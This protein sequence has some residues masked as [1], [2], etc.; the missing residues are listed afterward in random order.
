MNSL[1]I[2]LDPEVIAQFGERIRAI[3]PHAK[4][5][6]I[7]SDGAIEGGGAGVTVW[8]RDRFHIRV[9]DMVLRMPDLRWLHTTSTGVDHILTPTVMANDIIVTNSAGAQAIP[10]AE[11][12]IGM[13]VAIVKRFP[14]HWR[15]QTEARW[16]RYRKDELYGKTLV[17]VGTGHIGREIARR[18]R[19]FGM[20]TI[21]VTSIPRD[22][23]VFDRLLSYGE[24]GEA[25]QVADFVVVAAAM[26][27]ERKRLIKA[28]HLAGMKPTAWFINIARGDL[29]DE[30]GL[31]KALQT[32]TIAGAYLDVFT[33]EPLPA[34]HPFW[35][36]P[37]VYVIPHNT[38]FSVQS[39][40][41][42][43]EYFITNLERWVKAE[44]L[45]NVVDKQRGY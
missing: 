16:E 8:V 24:L 35:S 5:A 37:N 32:K 40:L 28:T 15:N 7:A 36:L 34:N 4:I 45:V 20:T 10:I 29:V 13:M 14:D 22:E 41:R 30:T 39:R 33:Q 17:I 6:P 11:S 12:V 18:G 31:L 23:P 9:E 2:A 44:P 38:A 21:G 3:A 25:M 1:R 27:A 19:A 43:L 42:G 26:T